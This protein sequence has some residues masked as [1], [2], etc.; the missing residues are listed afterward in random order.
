MEKPQLFRR[1]E[2]FDLI[3]KPVAPVGFGVKKRARVKPWW[4]NV[5]HDQM[6]RRGVCWNTCTR[7][8]SASTRYVA[9]LGFV[10]I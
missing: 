2:S 1:K 9:L 8:L 10:G 4:M 7:R 6:K 5:A 3:A